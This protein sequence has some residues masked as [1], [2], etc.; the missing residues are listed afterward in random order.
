MKKRITIVAIL[1]LAV[2]IM[3]VGCSSESK[4]NGKYK[5]SGFFSNVTYTFDGD[6]KVTIKVGSQGAINA[7][8]TVSGSTVTIVYAGDASTGTIGDDTITITEDGVSMV[9]TKQ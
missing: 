7:T 1:L 6:G 3:C 9:L 8:Y 5:G 4:L 2:L